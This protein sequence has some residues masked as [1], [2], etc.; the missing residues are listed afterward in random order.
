MIVTW[1]KRFHVHP[2]NVAG[3]ML[4]LLVGILVTIDSNRNYISA[5]CDTLMIELRYTYVIM[6]QCTV[7]LDYLALGCCVGFRLDNFFLTCN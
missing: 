7:I 2:S 5:L 1:R 3:L 4:V 6:N